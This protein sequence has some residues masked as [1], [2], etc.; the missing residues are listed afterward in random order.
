MSVKNL[1]RLIKEYLKAG[2][3]G[4]YDP[5]NPTGTISDEK[6]LE[7]Y[8]NVNL[9]SITKDGRIHLSIMPK[10]NI[11]NKK[12]KLALDRILPV[13]L[14]FNDYNDA[15]QSKDINLQSI[16]SVISKYA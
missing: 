8:V 7:D 10:K 2:A 9:N 3:G 14:Y 11:E 15:E 13:N 6:I 5:T 1:K 4:T 12:I 16:K